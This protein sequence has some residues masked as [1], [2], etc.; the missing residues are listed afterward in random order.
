MTRFARKPASDFGAMSSNT[1]A[2]FAHQA[3]PNTWP[4]LVSILPPQGQIGQGMVCP[5]RVSAICGPEQLPIA[6][7]Q[8]QWAV[9]NLPF[10]DYRELPDHVPYSQTHI[11]RGVRGQIARIAQSH[12]SGCDVPEYRIDV[13]CQ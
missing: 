4:T 2:Q 3:D 13:E 10:R 11:V 6:M 8:I 1:P 7:R 5:I 12:Q 9:L